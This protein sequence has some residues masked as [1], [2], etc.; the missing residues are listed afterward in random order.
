M[1]Q[2]PVYLIK[3]NLWERVTSALWEFSSFFNHCRLSLFAWLS[4]IAGAKRS[5]ERSSIWFVPNTAGLRFL[6]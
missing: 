6:L 3:K 4:E 5:H 1:P 2:T